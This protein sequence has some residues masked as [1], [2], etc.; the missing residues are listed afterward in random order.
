MSEIA[1]KP[2]SALQAKRE[3]YPE[4]KFEVHLLDQYKLYVEMADRVSARRMQ[5]S[6]MYMLVLSAAATA[7]ALV[8]DKLSDKAKPLQLVLAMAALF[9]GVLWHRS[10]A[11]YRDLNEAKF[12]VIHE[13]EA[14]LGHHR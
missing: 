1:D 5:A 9:I 12:K 13:M 3:G 14:G 11:Y 8:P 7:F 4:D 10:L 6:N 2:I